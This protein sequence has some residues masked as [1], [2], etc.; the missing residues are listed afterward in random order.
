MHVAGEFRRNDHPVSGNDR[1]PGKVVTNDHFAVAMRIDVGGVE[2]VSP[3][4]D[5]RLE[6]AQALIDP[7]TDGLPFIAEGH[8]SQAKRTDAK[9]G[10]SERLIV[11][12]IHEDSFQIEKF[13]GTNHAVRGLTRL[14]HSDSKSHVLKKKTDREGKMMA[15]IQD[16]PVAILVFW[17]GSTS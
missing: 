1:R 17:V 12:Q 4:L 5:V 3:G 2:E 13:E 11:G 14:R 10:S 8:A 15:S 6:N 9:A 16:A 7:S